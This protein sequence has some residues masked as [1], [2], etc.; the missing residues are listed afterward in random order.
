MFTSADAMN[1]LGSESTPEALHREEYHKRPARKAARPS[2]EV[3][4][5]AARRTA[6]LRAQVVTKVGAFF[7]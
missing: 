4:Y 1:R 6:L 5:R 7:A 2:G 3:D